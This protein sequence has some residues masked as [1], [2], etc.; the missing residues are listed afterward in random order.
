VSTS[1][2][3][4]LP[5]NGRV[6]RTAAPC[7]FS[8]DAVCD[9][10]HLRTVL[11]NVIVPG[12]LKPAKLKATDAQSL[13]LSGRYESIDMD[14]PRL[15]ALPNKWK[16][17][18]TQ[19]DYSEYGDD[20]S[21][22]VMAFTAGCAAAGIDDDLIASCLITWEIG[23]HIRD[24]NNVARSLTRTIG[25]AKDYVADP[26]LAEMNENHCVISDIGGKCLVLNE[27]IDPAT[28]N[29]RV[30]FSTFDAL[31]HR[32]GNRMK[33]LQ[34]PDGEKKKPIATWWSHHPQ[35]R[36]CEQVVFAPGKE[37]PN[38]YNLW[39]GFAVAPDHDDSEKKCALYLAHIRENLC[40][41]N[42]QLYNYIL[43]WM[44]NG[45]QYPGR[46]GGV[47]LV[48]RG[49]M[50]I[51]KGEYVRHYGGLFG[52][53][54]I[55]VTKPEHITGQFNGHM[56]EAIVLF[57]DECFIAS[58]NRHEQ[59][60]KVLVT[61]RQWLIEKKG[62]DAV[63]SNSCLHIILACNSE[64]SVP[65][66]A[67]D[68]RYC[69]IEVGDGRKR[70]HDYFAA[71]DEQMQRGGRAALL[72]LLL[73]MDLTGF[74]AEDFPRTAEHDRQRARTRHG[75]DAFIEEICHEGRLPCVDGMYPDVAITSGE[76]K[77]SGFD[78][79]IRNRAR[80]LRHLTPIQ[81][82]AELNKKWGCKTFR[83]STGARRTGVRFPPLAELRQRFKDEH[84]SVEWQAAD[85]E[86]W[87]APGAV[88]E[89]EQW[90]APLDRGAPQ[91]LASLLA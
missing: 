73:K 19:G 69:C 49:K 71:L 45:V 27:T 40:R 31:N 78:H 79:Y 87:D 24:Q 3:K 50:G 29:D 32:Y 81:V 90:D 60:L 47:A 1:T 8:R 56:G 82:K 26:D 17:L 57:A 43:R 33:T 12:A 65:V 70:D 46:P 25:R 58:D 91:D 10:D 37:I 85:T 54:F 88:R 6:P 38:A 66:D 80:E 39:Q 23:E 2:K 16:R 18:G 61:E 35:R 62:I 20:R 83:E 55:A 34:T 76:E 21:R 84:G 77:G 30:T 59:I 64:W 22:A 86:D 89:V 28:G 15:V 75:I 36:Q 53:H 51:G 9:V 14:D 74:H 52:P 63:R 44:A 13:V 72:G 48:L 11:A 5:T 67:D 4:D 41:G 42:E 68:R 7:S